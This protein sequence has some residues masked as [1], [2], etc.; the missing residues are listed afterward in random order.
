MWHHVWAF[1]AKVLDNY[2]RVVRSWAVGAVIVRKG[3]VTIT[4]SAA[5]GLLRC[6]TLY[7]TFSYVCL[8][9]PS[10]SHITGLDKGRARPRLCLLLHRSP[11]QRLAYLLYQHIVLVRYMS[12]TGALQPVNECR[13]WVSLF[14]FYLIC[15]CFKNT[16]CRISFSIT[17]SNLHTHVC[18]FRFYPICPVISN[19]FQQHVHGYVD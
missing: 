3:C 16:R 15:L 5:S 9:G 13:Q 10:N 1:Q 2:W 19:N 7:L 8:G 14:R 18:L 12:R 4:L 6:T 11:K 17:A